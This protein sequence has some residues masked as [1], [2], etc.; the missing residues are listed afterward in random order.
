MTTT[1]AE[2]R[3]MLC[4]AIREFFGE[5]SGPHLSTALRWHTRGVAGPH[6]ERIKLDCVRIGG[7]LYTSQAAL[8][9]FQD[10]CNGLAAPVDGE[11]LEPADEVG[12]QNEADGY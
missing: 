3:V 9:R 7:R 12:R 2:K 11:P 5:H 10:R 4:K 8:Q 1:A 6:G